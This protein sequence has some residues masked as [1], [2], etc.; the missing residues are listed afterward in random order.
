MRRGRGRGFD[1]APRRP[2][3]RRCAARGAPCAAGRACRAASRSAAAGATASSAPDE[4]QVGHQPARL[5]ELG[6]ACTPRSRVPQHLGRAP[7]HARAPARRAAARRRGV[8]VGSG[9]SAVE[10]EHDL[11]DGPATLRAGDVPVPARTRRTRGRRRRCPRAASPAS[12]GRPSTR[13]RAVRGRR[14]RAPARTASSRR[15]DVEP[16][17]AQDARERDRDAIGFGVARSGTARHRGAHELTDPVLAH[18]LLVLAV[19]QDR[20][21]R[22]VDRVLVEALRRRASRAPA[23][24]RSSP[25][26]PAACRARARA[27]PRPRP[28]PRAR[29][30]RAPRARAAAG[31]RARARSR[32]ARS[33]GRGSGAS[34]R[35]AR[36]ACGST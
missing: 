8:V 10:R 31:S 13:R 18:A 20:A 34:A 28:R 7:P 27:A 35:R 19:L 24:S 22:D 1:E 9:S 23:P 32:D 5:G 25:R 2:A 12:P 6:R 14:A 11:L 30:R 3:R 33:S 29:A 4:P 15:R 21:E 26:R 16:G 36:R 17:A